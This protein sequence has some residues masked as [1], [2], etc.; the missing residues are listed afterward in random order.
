MPE[1]PSSAS[2]ARREGAVGERPAEHGRRGERRRGG[3]RGAQA[4]GVSGRADRLDHREA[5][6]RPGPGRPD[7]QPGGGQR[8]EQQRIHQQGT[9]VS[10]YMTQKTLRPW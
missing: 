2:P 10:K 7:Q 9:L 1:A 8:D 6:R 3:E 5:A 4:A